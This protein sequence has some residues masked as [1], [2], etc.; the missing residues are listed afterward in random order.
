MARAVIHA[1]PQVL[2]VRARNKYASTRLERQHVCI[3]TAVCFNYG[4]ARSLARPVF[5]STARYFTRARLFLLIILIAHACGTYREDR[6]AQSEAK[7]HATWDVIISETDTIHGY[8][9]AAVF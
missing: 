1:S 7:T 2:K 5:S 9:S 4:Q 6:R 8:A 3:T